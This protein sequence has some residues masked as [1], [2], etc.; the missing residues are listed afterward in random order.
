MKLKKAIAALLAAV[1]SIGAAGAV[2]AEE[3]DYAGINCLGAF[4]WSA[5]PGNITAFEEW[6]GRDIQRK[7]SIR[8]LMCTD[9]PIILIT[10]PD[11]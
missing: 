2:T 6:L 1:I 3:K 5:N 4:A 9:Q 7:L 8:P 10:D 11:L